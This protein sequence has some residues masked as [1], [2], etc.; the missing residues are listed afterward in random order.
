MRKKQSRVMS[1]SLNDSI[2][3]GQTSVNALGVSAE[4]KHKTLWLT[5]AVILAAST[6]TVAIAQPGTDVEEVIVVGSR[7]AKPR[8]ASDSPVPVD[9]FSSEDLSRVGGGADITDSLNA[10]VPSYLASPATGD[11]SA[12]VRPTSLRGLASDQTLVLVNGS[13]RH[14]SSL[15][16][17]FAPAANNGSHGTDIA[18]I[19]GI[20]LKNIEV[21][22]DGAAAQYGSDAIAGVINFQ[23]KDAAEG[24]SVEATYGNHFE[25]ESSWKLAANAGLALGTEGFINLSLETNDNEALSRG[26]QNPGAQTLIDNGVDGVGG[27]AVFGDAPLVQ[28]W[29]RPETSGTRFVFNAGYELSDTMSLFSFGNYAKTDGRYRF[30]YRDPNN[31]DLAESLAKGATNL[32]RE[33]AAGYTPYLDGEQTDYSLVLGLKG[34][35]QNETTYSASLS[36]GANALDYTLNNSLNG[37]ADLVGTNAVRVF[38]TGDYEQKEFNINVDFGTQL[39]SDLFLAY[40]AEYRDETFT[41]KSGD[42]AAYTGGGVSGLAGTRPEDAGKYSRDNYAVYVD[43]EQEATD[44]LLMQYAVRYEDFSD[45]G[46]TTNWKI[47]SRYRVTDTFALRGAISTGFHAPTPGQANL[48]STTTTINGSNQVVDVGLLPA[49][50]PEVASLGGKALTEEVATNYSFGFTADLF[51]ATTLAIDAYR[52]EVDGRIYRAEIDSVSFYTNALD[53]LH[54]GVDVV[55]TSG[56]E[57][58]NDYTTDWVFAYT[59]GSVEVEGNSLV[60]GAQVVSDD[61]V[62]DIENN[63][64]NDKFTFSATTAFSDNISVLARI[65]YIGDHYDER[66]T[67]AGTPSAA[68]PVNVSQQIDAVMYTDLEV[69]Y[70]P[71]MSWTVTLGGSNIFDEYPDEIEDE[72]GVANRISVGL[73]YPRRSVANYEGGYWYGKVTYQF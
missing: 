43:L 31:S 40:G 58:G 13:R 17:L 24:G 42:Q 36:S 18:M 39:N 15:V 12:F 69:S 27:D 37:D 35:F 7:S 46:G 59:Y 4:F 47:A 28:T 52:I 70:S 26:R 66:G 22:R 68:G 32:A 21:L 65:R 41:Q 49:D 25:G 55:L 67:I 3:N 63:Y 73:P 8:T 50:S 62:E 38:N 51:D 16:Q 23:L 1:K 20:A 14:R 19:P 5:T 10:L 61:F 33:T 57:W 9:V 45:F 71:N 60:N 56:V 30:F 64:P 2:L 11:G 34:E 48:R 6:H 72:Q 54:Q 29:G 44:A 53:I